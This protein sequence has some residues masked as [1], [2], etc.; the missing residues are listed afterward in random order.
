MHK[1]ATVPYWSPLPEELSG[2]Q[3]RLVSELRSLKD[4]NQLTFKQIGR[5]THYSHASWERWLNGKRPIT[6]PAVVGLATALGV[7]AAPLR[8][9]FDAAVAGSGA[10]EPAHPGGRPATDPPRTQPPDPTGS[11][12]GVLRQLPAD[13]ST[14]TGRAEQLRQLIESAGATM[15]D[16]SAGNTPTTV[17]ISA[18]EGMGGVGKTQLALHAAHELARSGRFGDLQLYANLRGFDHEHAPADPSA[19][20]D[21]FL[22]Q[23]EVPAPRIPPSRAERAAMFRDRLHGKHALIVLDNAADEAQVRDLIPAAAGCLVLLT[24]R[25][26]L[27]GLDGATTHLLDVF[28]E[29]EAVELLGRIAGPKRVAEE[30]EAAAAVVR[31]CG[32]LPLAISLAAARLRTRPSW[33]VADLA[34]RLHDGDIEA[35][36]IGDRSLERVFDLSYRSLS[37][38]VR[39]TFRLLG[40]F[41]GRDF[42][43]SA[44]AALTGSSMAETASIMED[45]LDE[46]LL[47]QRVPSRYEFH[48][49][50]GSYARRCALADET[51]AERE[52]ALE[53]LLLWYAHSADNATAAIA[54]LA[55]RAVLR[56]SRYRATFESRDQA[57][58]WS[59]RELHNVIACIHEGRLRGQLELAWQTA[60]SMWAYLRVTSMWDVALACFTVGLQAAEDSGD[61]AGLAS[62]HTDL[63]TRWVRVGDFDRALYHH[64]RALESNVA[65][66]SLKGQAIVLN[67]LGALHV[68]RREYEAAL[69]CLTRSRDLPTLFSEGGIPALNIGEVLGLMGRHD[70]AV[71][72]LESARALF[73]H[74]G[75]EY[76]AASAHAALGEV[77]LRAGDTDA[78]EA[79]TK[80]AVDIRESIGYQA[81]TA[82]ALMVLGDVYVRTH[83]HDDARR[84]WNR[85]LAVY[86]ELE[87]EAGIGETR[88]RLQSLNP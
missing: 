10:P 4:A 86:E 5:M 8:E 85:A 65:R 16:A 56:P 69:E 83:H 50:I 7:Q 64:Q 77:Y 12:I 70:E 21:A 13:L 22:R 26:T 61:L 75:D 31:A 72:E 36:R 40:L 27:A 84:T 45:L 17:V 43:V 14:F 63:A 68:R 24:S 3:R 2:A 38:P 78:A 37:E 54:P 39:R 25:R 80:Q 6:W 19:V 67:N 82:T 41:P 28:D 23:L 29:S 87:D 71:R 35:M 74:S 62:M 18:I 66:A 60:G 55:D 47:E 11:S 81:G 30:P 46:H 51:S 79:A 9:M 52:E 57:M 15:E 20:L 53:R 73:F 58:D 34:E 42:S 48:D 49:L 32:F 76:L 1:E 59:R 88:L 33:T 44:A